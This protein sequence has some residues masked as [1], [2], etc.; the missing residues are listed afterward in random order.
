[1]PERIHLGLDFGTSNC[2]VGAVV[3]QK[4][5]VLKVQNGQLNEPSC[6]Y[7]D[8]S[9]LFNVVGY[10]ALR[11][12]QRSEKT[13]NFHFVP[14]IK[15]G[16]HYPDYHG[17][18][19]RSKKK[20]SLGWQRVTDF[21]VER[22]A[23]LVIEDLKLHADVHLGVDT[24]AVLVGR[25]VRFS[26]KD[27]EDQLAQKRLEEAAR[28]VGFRQV[29][30][31]YEPVAAGLH[32]ARSRPRLADEAVLVFDFGGGTLDTACLYLAADSMFTQADLQAGILSTHGIDLGGS[33]LDKDL[34]QSFIVPFLGASAFWGDKKL[35]IPRH[36]YLDIADWHLI[37]HTGKMRKLA[38]LRSIL[39]SHCS[40]LTGIRNL[41][42][43]IE[44]QQVFG[45]L[46]AIE[47]AKIELSKQEKSRITYQQERIDFDIPITRLQLE[48]IVAPR[49][50]EMD[51]CVSEC[52]RLAQLQDHQVDAVIKVGG[53]SN[54]TFVDRFLARRFTNVVQ[55]DVFNS[56]VAGLALAAN[57]LFS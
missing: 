2:S 1:M 22:M 52:L 51:N 47:T 20:D 55:G 7:L 33:D 34:F 16:L 31:L 39:H 57:E 9:D 26:D 43:M 18:V 8:A 23:A 15:P 5:R 13:D 30:F 49:V 21:S 17:I 46:Q 12:F 29:Q 28:M 48:K 50:K 10:V 40:D 54:N 37:D 35:P 32:Y 27:G 45:V 24:D 41:L 11:A 25:P 19:L 14:S 36:F 56:V 38:A 42:A 4:L 53:S 44:K 6:I 3:D